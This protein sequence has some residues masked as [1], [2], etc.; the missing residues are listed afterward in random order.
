M[1][2]RRGS[3]PSSSNGLRHVLSGGLNRT[4]R[5]KHSGEAGDRTSIA[6][7]GSESHHGIRHSIESAIDKLKHGDGEDDDDHGLKKLVPSRIKSKRRRRK[8]EKEGNK[9]GEDAARGRIISERGYLDND[10]GSY[11]AG[12][13]DGSSLI[14]VESETES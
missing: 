11:T 12:D 8:E 7:D 2:E 9:Y 4:I 6:S 13:V 14:T 3:S 10:Q 5:S 1:S